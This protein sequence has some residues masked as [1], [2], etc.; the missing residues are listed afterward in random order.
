MPTGPDDT[1]P[2]PDALLAAVH[3]V[4]DFRPAPRRTGGGGAAAAPESPAPPPD[5]GR[6]EAAA[7]VRTRMRFT[8]DGPAL[9]DG[10]LE[11]VD[12]EGNPR[13][14]DRFLVAICLCK[15]SRTYPLCDT[16][17]R[18]RRRAAES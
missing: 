16:T 1:P 11:V 6:H 10:P 2:D 7:E 3:G 4:A 17:H 15:R 14:A 12:A 8:P 18:R 13:C 9:I 5:A